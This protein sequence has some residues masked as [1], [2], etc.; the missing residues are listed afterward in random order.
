LSER[1]RAA[2]REPTDDGVKNTEN[3]QVAPPA[4]DD[5]QV[6]V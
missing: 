3:M 2:L 5:P 1:A 4:R 6:L